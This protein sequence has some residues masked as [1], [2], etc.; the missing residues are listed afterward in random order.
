M[1]G[2]TVSTIR[3][4]VRFARRVQVAADTP[5]PLRRSGL[6]ISRQT[7]DMITLNRAMEFAVEPP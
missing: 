6:D 7:G 2:E 4:Y 3:F 5:S 1:I